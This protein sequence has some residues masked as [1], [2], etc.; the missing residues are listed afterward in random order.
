MG[1]HKGRCFRALR[2]VRNK[3]K[4]QR[5]RKDGGIAGIGNHNRISGPQLRYDTAINLLGG[6]FS[7][8]KVARKTARQGQR[9]Q[10]M[11]AFILIVCLNGCGIPDTPIMQ[12]YD[13]LIDCEEAQLR[14]LEKAYP[15]DVAAFCYDTEKKMTVSAASRGPSGHHWSSGENWC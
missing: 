5:Q 8:P 2:R 9:G 1:A 3:H 4:L 6:F 12:P 7:M 11:P 13:T 10:W 14:A 15:K